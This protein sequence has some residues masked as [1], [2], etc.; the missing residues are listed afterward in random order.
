MTDGFRN[1]VANLGTTR[2]KASASSYGYSELSELELFNAYKSGWLPRKIIDIPP[3]DATRKWRNWQASQDQIELIEAAEKTHNLRGKVK[4]AM[5]L[6]RLWGGSAI[7]IGTGDANLREPLDPARVAA[8]GLRYLTVMSK[9]QLTPTAIETDPISPRYGTPSMYTATGVDIHP[10]R[11]AIFHGAEVPDKDLQVGQN[12]GWG[13]SILQ[14]I[15]DAV[16]NADS[17]AANVA[18]LVFEAKIDVFKIPDLMA[19]LSDPDFETAVTNRLMLAAQLKGI[20]GALIMDSLEDYQQKTAS[21][22]TLPDIMD[23]FMQMVSGAADIPMTRLMGQA[24]AGLNATG[25]GDLRN[26]YD[27]IQALQELDLSPA[28]QTLDEVLIRSAL[29]SRPP[30][31]WYAWASLWQTTDKERADI[32]KTLADTIKALAE[33]N[34]IPSDAL[35]IAAINA[36]T[37]SGVMPGLEQAAEESE[38]DDTDDLNAALGGD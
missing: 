12:Y 4:Q 28:L 8:G 37:E 32:G 29:G 20:N 5:T 16:K 33:T 13:D 25:E 27:R 11:L 15:Y 7:F 22:A 24:A 35:S 1:I 2:D 9:R 18:A 19:K 3:L 10:S 36:L 23:R 34:L 30:E 6:A 31:V 21:F 38:T 26:Y 14:S 17:T